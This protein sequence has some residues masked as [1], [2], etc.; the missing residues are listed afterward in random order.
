MTKLP[1]PAFA[2][3]S[4]LPQ[5]R[6]APAPPP[7]PSP[8]PSNGVEAVIETSIDVVAIVAACAVGALAMLIL[9]QVLGFFLRRIGRRHPF[10]KY[11]ERRSRI[12][13]GFASAILGI[14]FGWLWSVSDPA[15]DWY[16]PI[17]HGLLIAAIAAI[18][19]W[20]MSLCA[21]LEDLTRA[22]RED[23]KKPNRLVTQA[24][25]LHRVLQVFLAVTGII[26]I[27]LTFPQARTA[28]GSIL[29]SAGLISLIAG[30]AAQG[31]LANMFAGLQIAFSDSIRVGDL[32]VVEKE[33]GNIEEIT[34]TYVVVLLWDGRRLILPSKKFTE[35]VFENWT[36]R[37]SKLLGTVEIHADWRLPMASLR[38]EVDR[39]LNDTDLWDGRTASVQVTQSSPEGMV[40]RLVVSAPN[41]GDLWDLRCYMREHLIDWIQSETPYALPRQRLEPEEIETV[42][43]P[44][45]E[46]DLDRQLRHSVIAE[47]HQENA[48][49]R[50][51]AVSASEASATSTNPYGEPILDQYARKLMDRRRSWREKVQELDSQEAQHDV[52]GT[53]PSGRDS[54][55]DT[56]LLS[57]TATIS[58]DRFYS[59]SPDAD[60][61]REKVV[62]PK[63]EAEDA[64]AEP[65]NDSA[66]EDSTKA[67]KEN[68]PKA[69]QEESPK[70][71]ANDFPQTTGKTPSDS[72]PEEDAKTKSDS[73]NSEA[74][75]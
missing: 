69:N 57:T 70:A 42:R 19:W 59:G 53:L 66:K 75:S 44:L 22:R 25:V 13:G 52:A 14:N 36:K 8:N 16:G 43:L 34:L 6:T 54:L 73:T 9:S 39:L 49:R 71:P 60:A 2:I 40:V 38:T 65:E 11:F 64:A 45:D 17:S 31:V 18:T 29:A 41:S 35:D 28:M 23:P 7:S 63:R 20:L 51:K 67:T 26:I 50:E 10:I 58:S 3:S 61:R 68:S 27:A 46:I 12:S 21:V 4:L 30:I 5:G 37:D 48:R 24:Q 56:K 32:V 55:A 62:G 72:L 1:L 74:A 15:S 47:A 33:M